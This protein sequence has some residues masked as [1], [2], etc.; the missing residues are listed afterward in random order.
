MLD[1]KT[2]DTLKW[3]AILFLPSL[4]ALVGTIGEAVNFEYTGLAVI[5]INAIAVFIG[6]IIK[7][8]TDKYNKG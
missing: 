6:S 3:I 4:S 2:Y 5:V 8:S 1:N 7:V